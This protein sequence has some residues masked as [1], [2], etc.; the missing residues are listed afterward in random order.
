MN[1]KRN[2]VLKQS[3][4]AEYERRV[5]LVTKA[6]LDGLSKQDII[7]IPTV[8][9]WG[10]S[11]RQ[12][13]HYIHDAHI[14]VSEVINK[15]RNI[16]VGLAFRKYN[17]IYQKALAE[18]NYKEAN[19]AITNQLKALGLLDSNTFIQQNN[20]INNYGRANEF[21]G[22]E[23]IANLIEEFAER[24]IEASYIESNAFD[25]TPNEE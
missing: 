23:K 21:S 5:T 13:G 6:L 11:I 14:R 7:N 1:R 22:N 16:I 3:N 24:S 15:E 10:V 8:Q 2:E 25:A 18:K 17:R 20:Q 12:I 19:N 9:K 4:S